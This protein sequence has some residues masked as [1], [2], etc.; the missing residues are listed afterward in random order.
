VECAIIA[1]LSKGVIITNN[2]LG[3]PEFTVITVYEDDD[4]R[5]LMYE[6]EAVSSPRACPKCG[7]VGAF[8]KHTLDERIVQD[9]PSH[10]KLAY[11]KIMSRRYKC[12]DCNATFQEEF[13]CVD[14][15][16]RLTARFR[17]H[18]QEMCLTDTFARIARDSSLSINTVRRIFQEYI[19]EKSK[20]LV[21]KA[22]R[23][24]GIDED[25]VNKIFR[26]VITDSE[27][28]ELLDILPDRETST[29]TSFFNRMDEKRNVK[30]VTMDMY[31]PYRAII[32]NT[33]PSAC[34][35]VDKFH[36]VQLTNRKMDEV[37]KSIRDNMSAAERKRFLYLSKLM[38]SN[39]EDISERSAQTLR[40]AFIEYPILGTAYYLKEHI[41]GMYKSR[42]RYEAGQLFNQVRRSIPADCASLVTLK[43]SLEEWAEE[44]MNYFDHPY[45]NAYTESANNLIKAI[46]KESRSMSFEQLRYKILFYTRATKLPRFRPKQAAY[47][48][49]NSYSMVTPWSFM[50]EKPQLERGFG[51]DID[52]LIEEL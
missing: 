50:D 16:E 36:V 22:P 23:V 34:I 28:N 32:K 20:L 39:K 7:C 42:S 48:P 18:L 35:V 21:Y 9:I 11:L 44:I 24:L 15:K 10:G 33:F 29:I 6:V 41:R 40:D 5:S 47:K 17:K 51:V 30:V 52:A 25:H 4:S 46:N 45:T 43:N 19:D 2:S 37:R 49:S 38:K 13:D 1:P 26:F 8:Y 14:G 27:N 3:L 31:R 12:K